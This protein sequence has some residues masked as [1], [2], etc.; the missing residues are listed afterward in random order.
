[1]FHACAQLRSSSEWESLNLAFY[2]NHHRTTRMQVFIWLQGSMRGSLTQDTEKLCDPI[3]PS[4]CDYQ[5]QMRSW[6]VDE[7]SLDV[8]RAFLGLWIWIHCNGMVVD[9]ILRIKMWSIGGTLF[10][11]GLGKQQHQLTKIA[12]LLLVSS[13]CCP[14]H[15]QSNTRLIPAQFQFRWV[16]WD[17]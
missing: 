12:V 17:N 9:M 13:L 10:S 5:I 3:Y 7:R 8:W 6:V 1:M 14:L 4:L 11:Y 2:S 15:A 16:I